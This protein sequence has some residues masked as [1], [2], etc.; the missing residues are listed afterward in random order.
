MEELAK[1]VEVVVVDVTNVR[2]EEVE[3]QYQIG[4]KKV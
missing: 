1:M 4:M 3:T 2:L